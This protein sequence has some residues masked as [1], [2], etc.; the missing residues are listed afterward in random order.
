MSSLRAKRFTLLT[1]THL[2]LALGDE[3]QVD[4]TGDITISPG[5]FKHYNNLLQNLSTIIK[6]V[7]SLRTR[8]ANHDVDETLC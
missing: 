8:N 6:T 2:L 5:D 3:P 1:P 7:G 4:V